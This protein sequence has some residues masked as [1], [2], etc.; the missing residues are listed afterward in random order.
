VALVAEYAGAAA[1]PCL[2]SVETDPVVPVAKPVG[3]P[4]ID[5]GIVER[6]G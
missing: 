1:T 6:R 3:T 5:E 2:R 4:M